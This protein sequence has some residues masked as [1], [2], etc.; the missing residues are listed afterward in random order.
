MSKLTSNTMNFFCH[1]QL[2]KPSTLSIKIPFMFVQHLHGN[3]KKS[4]LE[5]TLAAYPFFFL[6]VFLLKSPSVLEV[7]R[8][9]SS[10]HNVALSDRPEIPSTCISGM[11]V[12][13]KNK[14]L[15]AGKTKPSKLA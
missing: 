1:L 13:G 6:A 12:E 10:H 5:S 3:Y 8:R 7:T 4:L 11:G 15:T 2:Y 14:Q 9:I